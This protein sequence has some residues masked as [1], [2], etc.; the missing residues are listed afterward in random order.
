MGCGAS[1]KKYK[2]EEGGG[3]AEFRSLKSIE[4]DQKKKQEAAQNGPADA[5][6]AAGT[7]P[8]SE[9]EQHMLRYRCESGEPSP[10]EGDE[11]EAAADSA[12]AAAEG[13]ATAPE[14]PAAAPAAP[15]PPTAPAS[16][17][18]EA[19]LALDLLL[20]GDEGDFEYVAQ[21]LKLLDASQLRTIFA[22]VDTD[23]S[24][25][26][27][28]ADLRALVFP[29]GGGAGA[30]GG[31]AAAVAKIF[32]QMDRN[33]DGRVS[34]AEFVAYLVSGR[35]NAA[36]LPTEA[37]RRHVAEAFNKADTDGSGR[38]SLAELETFL[39]ASSEEERRVLRA[40][41]ESLDTDQSGS[42]DVVEFARLYGT[43][44]RSAAKGAE[45]QG[46]MGAAADETDA[47]DTLS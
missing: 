2:A 4:M 21:R 40:T 13:A 38:V 28:V 20:D 8:A 39:C 36:A 10:A 29:E 33:C 1:S 37:E 43:E 26:I 17:D 5:P 18:E 41:F 6:A 16:A 25:D 31:E 44:L 11:P 30:S 14:A 23:A 12:K 7:E 27:G 9:A 24:G 22:G 35:R 47:A 46:S 15:A 45:V 3:Q 34:C 19:P 32:A 42:L